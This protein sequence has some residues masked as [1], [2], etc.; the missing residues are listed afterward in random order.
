MHDAAQELG[1]KRSDIVVSTK[2]FWGGD[3]PNDQG[4]SRKHLIEG[5]RASLHRLQLDY[6]DVL[7]CHRPDPNTPVEA[8][9]GLIRRLEAAAA[10]AFAFG[11]V[12]VCVW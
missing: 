6:V 4:L 1:W 8:R 7:F 9:N 3:G 5:T 11:C 10:S 12:C 2:I